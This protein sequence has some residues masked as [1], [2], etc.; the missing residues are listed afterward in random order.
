[1]EIGHNIGIRQEATMNN[2]IINVRAIPEDYKERRRTHSMSNLDTMTI[3]YRGTGVV[4]EI[5]GRENFRI[6]HV[7]DAQERIPPQ[8]PIE[9]VH[10]WFV[11]GTKP[12]EM[13]VS[14]EDFWFRNAQLCMDFCNQ[15]DINPRYWKRSYE[16]RAHRLKSMINME[17][18]YQDE[19]N[20]DEEDSNDDDWECEDDVRSV[21]E[22]LNKN[23]RSY[24][25]SGWWDEGDDE[26]LLT[27]ES[28]LEG[29]D[30]D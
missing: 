15:N 6:M 5:N 22:N 10:I 8:G 30:S 17:H 9:R 26:Y 23:L 18:E 4:H 16:A 27:D 12:F 20:A 19:Q 29:E 1:M 3:H 25:E 7:I 28:E 24:K 13:R 21:M 14:R 11:D 2:K